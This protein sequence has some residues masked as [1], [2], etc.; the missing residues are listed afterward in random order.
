METRNMV[1]MVMAV[2]GSVALISAALYIML[3][4][5]Y[6]QTTVNLAGYM[7]QA[8]VFAWI[9]VATTVEVSVDEP[10]PIRRRKK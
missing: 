3:N 10:A 1:I 8:V 4:G 2:V 6:S 5:G 9:K 7:A